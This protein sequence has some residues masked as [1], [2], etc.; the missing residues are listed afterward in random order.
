MNEFMWSVKFLLKSCSCYLQLSHSCFLFAQ[1]QTTWHVRL[2]FILELYEPASGLSEDVVSRIHIQLDCRLNI[3]VR[4][5]LVKMSIQSYAAPQLIGFDRE[6][7]KVL[8]H[9]ITICLELPIIQT[10]F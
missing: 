9:R 10:N 5:D 1:G 4:D 6:L 2:N 8:D 7:S 3:H